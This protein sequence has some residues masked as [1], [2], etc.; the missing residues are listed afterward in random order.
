MSSERDKFFEQLNQD[1][2]EQVWFG[3]DYYMR[4]GVREAREK[5]QR[6]FGSDVGEEVLCAI[7]SELA[8]FREA[9]SKDDI[10]L[11]NAAKRILARAGYWP[12]GEERKIIR[13]LRPHQIQPMGESEQ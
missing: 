5:M 7:L 9:V 8:W 10:V 3:P 12:E 6:V 4:P 1:P 2:P 13:R 11:Q